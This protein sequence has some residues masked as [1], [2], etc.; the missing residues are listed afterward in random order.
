[1]SLNWHQASLINYLGANRNFSAL[2]GGEIGYY[3][4]LLTD[5]SLT[6]CYS[7]F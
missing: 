4:I 1:M 3:N 5:N 2:P 7:R 6:F